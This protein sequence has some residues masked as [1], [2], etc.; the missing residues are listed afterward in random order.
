M[1]PGSSSST[2]ARGSSYSLGRG[3]SSQL[4][5][6]V[7]GL[8]RPGHRVLGPVVIYLFLGCIWVPGCLHGWAFYFELFLCWLRTLTRT[9]HI[10][11]YE[12]SA[13]G[14]GHRWLWWSPS[15][16]HHKLLPL[17]L[18]SLVPVPHGTL[19]PVPVPRGRLPPTHT[20][21]HHGWPPHA[22]FLVSMHLNFFA[23]CSY[24]CR[25]AHPAGPP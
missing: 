15:A 8:C 4:A 21:G 7:P 19:S 11:L 20:A 23:D 5:K 16:S 25:G 24:S 18:M 14:S 13:W 6:V 17:L 1:R 12:A 3:R 9:H 22:S 2:Q 10:V